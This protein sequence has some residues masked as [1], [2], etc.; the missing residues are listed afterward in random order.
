MRS[1]AAAPS[2][3][4]EPVD[5]VRA[6]CRDASWAPPFG[7]VPGTT[8][9]EGIPGQTQISLEGLYI[10]SGIRLGIPQE[11]LEVIAG[12]KEV[13]NT[14]PT[15]NPT[16]CMY[17][18]EQLPCGFASFSVVCQPPVAAFPVQLSTAPADK[19]G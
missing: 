10:P 9:C 1:S 17:I 15:G 18:A 12:E 19:W 16:G 8:N 4:K 5:V 3:Q 7:C 2:C 14:L 6:S 13:W 11:E